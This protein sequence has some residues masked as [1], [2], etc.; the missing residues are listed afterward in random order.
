MAKATRRSRTRGRPAS[1]SARRSRG[2]PA[3]KSRSRSRSHG[4]SNKKKRRSKKVGGSS[5]ANIIS[6]LDRL[7]SEEPINPSEITAKLAE[8][9][10]IKENFT[11]D[12][13]SSITGLLS[14]AEEKGINVSEYK[15]LSKPS[16][17]AAQLSAEEIAKIN[18]QGIKASSV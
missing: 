18:A 10:A 4:R 7:L 9:L 12:E 17:F 11:R 2:R 5:V 16:Y 8:L 15:I 1:K 6:E 14:R 3:S 13:K